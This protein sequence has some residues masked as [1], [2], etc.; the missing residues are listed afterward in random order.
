MYIDM[1]PDA[2]IESIVAEADLRVLLLCLFQLTG[3]DRWLEPPFQPVRDVRLIAD[4]AAGFGSGV[5]SEIRRAAVALFRDG[6]PEPV[7]AAPDDATLLHMMRVCLAEKVDEAYVPMMREQLGF[8][9]AEVEWSAPAKQDI[10][11]R[12]VVVVGAGISG[13]AIGAQLGRLGFPY[14]VIEKSAGVGGTWFE[15][16]Y[17]GCRVDTPNHAYSFS[18]GKPHPWSH[19]F[20]P[21]PEIRAYLDR[22]ADDFGVR[23][24]IRFES[25]VT[26]ATWS[27]S[28]RL[29][30]V[31][32]RQRTGRVERIAA[33]ALVSAIGQ[34]NRPAIP[35]LD[36]IESFGGPA[37][38]SASWP[39][40]VDLRGKRVAVIGTGASAMQLVPSIAS[41]VERLTVYQRSPQWVRPIG[42]YHR[43]VSRGTQWLLDHVPFY[44]AWFRFT[45]LWR[46]GDGLLPFLRVDPS[47]PHPERSLNRGNDRHRQ[48]LVDHIEKSLQSRPEL[49]AK[50]T[51]TYPPYGKRMLIDNGWYET[52]LRDDVELVCEP[53]QRVELGAIVD[54][55]GT[56][57]PTDV[58]I[59]AT[60]FVVTDLTARLGVRGSGGR[61][62]A[63]VWAD[64]NPSAYLGI[65]VPAFPNLFCMYGPN[66]NLGHGGS[67]IFHAECQARYI[68]DAL[69]KMAEAGIAAL[70][71]RPEAH[72]RWVR[73][74]DE[75][76][77]QMI[78]THPGM[79]TWYR[80]RH[81]RVVSTSPFRL[82][83]YWSKTHD[84]DLADYDC[85]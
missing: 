77:S 22:C 19:Y 75:A 25:I 63:D 41:E 44:A 5:Q 28:E 62:L 11:A 7:I 16:R 8:T 33:H 1:P 38:H 84:V 68:S 64:D 66:T 35:A 4:E 65:A 30:Q 43:K 45:L 79:E 26:G 13:I 31:D 80:N 55:A 34:L 32:V 40:A 61:D 21:Q 81:G 58:I 73:E 6:I 39:G 72:D 14:T 76:H 15:N 17:P 2:D 27:E 82:V 67:I 50:C 57:R 85:V 36:G 56:R 54:G 69:V 20:S 23:P 51:P 83:D 47:W 48:E 53:I 52:L 78:W 18:F 71:C 37:F 60:G 49:I 12:H 59:Y 29:W 46:Y 70:E 42:H 10:D 3:D 24:N 9:S 74:V